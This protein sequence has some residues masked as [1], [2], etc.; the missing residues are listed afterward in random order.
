MTQ[1]ID[2]HFYEPSKG[3]GLKHSPFRAIV[4]PRPIA[5]VSSQ[6]KNGNVNLAPYSFFNAFSELPPIIGFGS[7]GPKDTLQNIEETGEFVVNM[8]SHALAQAMNLTSAGV[9]R[10]VDEMKLA[11]LDAVPSTLVKP[12]RVANTPVAMECKLLQIV[13]LHDVNGELTTSSL[14]LGQVIGVHLDKN[15]IKDGLFD[16]WAADPVMRAGYKADY[17]RM[18]EK[19]LM[20]RPD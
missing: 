15:C 17:V 18:G 13:P 14:V 1:A 6:D 7:Y 9:P 19:F 2:T 3:H 16:I 20:E 11:G 4:A 8:V 10:G 12:P 5:W